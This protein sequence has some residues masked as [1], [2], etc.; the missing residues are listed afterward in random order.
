MRPTLDFC[1]RWPGVPCRKIGL[2]KA[3]DVSRKYSGFPFGEIFREGTE[4]QTRREKS[5]VESR[6][7]RKICEFSSKMKVKL[8]PEIMSFCREG[9]RI[10]S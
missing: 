5:P 3:A 1:D 2:G 8:S 7:G 9:S 6:K 4:N 10:I